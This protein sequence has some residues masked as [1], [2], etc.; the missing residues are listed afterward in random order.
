[1]WNA[2]E[3]RVSK[4]EKERRDRGPAGLCSLLVS[5]CRI[6]SALPVA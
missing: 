6:Q 1:M 5:I 4:L 2:L 3:K